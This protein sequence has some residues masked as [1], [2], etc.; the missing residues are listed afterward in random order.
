MTQLNARIA[1][2]PLLVAEKTRCF[3]HV[4]KREMDWSGNCQPL[5]LLSIFL[6]HLQLQF[7]MFPMT[8][9]MDCEEYKLVAVSF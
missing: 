8:A 1:G 9:E 2:I 3:R 4:I 7:P 5:T 6:S